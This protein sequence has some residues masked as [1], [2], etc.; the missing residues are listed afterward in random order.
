MIITSKDEYTNTRG[1]LQ[2][3]HD[4]YSTD[5]PFPTIRLLIRRAN[6]KQPDEIVSL[7]RIELVDETLNVTL[8]VKNYGADLAREVTFSV[9]V[10]ND[11]ELL[12]DWK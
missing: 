4:I 5:N 12:G 6:L 3:V 2:Y 11:D 8:S 1:L 10:S 7:H 9:F